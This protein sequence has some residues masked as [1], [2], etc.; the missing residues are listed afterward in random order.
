M[1]ISNLQIDILEI[2]YKEKKYLTLKEI[3]RNLTKHRVTSRTIQRELVTLIKN[4]RVIK[5]G[6]T[7]NAT[8]AIDEI[9]KY[10]RKFKFIFVGKDN[11]VAGL[12]FKLTDSYRFYYT[13]TF[14]LSFSE[15][16]PTIPLSVEYYDFQSIPPIFEENIPE[17][18]NREIIEIGAHTSDEFDLLTLLDDN[19]GDLI[20]TKTEE[21]FK[22]NDIKKHP[23]Y[24]SSLDEILG[25][26]SR[27]NILEDFDIKIDDKLLFPEGHDL[28]KL[29]MKMTH[30]ISGFQYKRL[31]NIDFEKKEIISDAKSA[32]IY[33]LKPYS[34]PKANPLNENYFPHIS[35]NEHLFMSFAKNELGFRVPYSAI[36]KR[37][38]DEEY[39]YIVKR[40][41]RLGINR[42]AKTTFAP[43]LGLISSTKYD[44]T[45]EKLFTRIA[46]ELLAPKERM[47]LL[48][49]YAYSVIIQHEDMH[50]K[51]L[52]LILES[53]KTLFAPLYD[54]SCTGI[55]DT[56]KK[57][58]SM[59]TINGKQK[60]I[61]PNDFKVL[62]KILNID[63]KEFKKEVSLIAT[64]YKNTLPEYIEEIKNLGSIPFYKSK[65]KKKI[66][67]DAEWVREKNPI[68]FSDVLFSFYKKRVEELKSLNWI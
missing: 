26:N 58:D 21:I 7:A 41:D 66:G 40:F 33:I 42:Y 18:I 31:V 37:K 39:H 44:T 1:S 28:S 67:N 49:H 17:G 51:N 22:N 47:E 55:Y 2:L 6:K 65:L 35:I 5:E 13:N 57:L 30:G 15:P 36:V 62:C 45:S 46:K 52:S 27:I 53:K 43:Y 4:H 32:N 48:K 9:V 8:Y 64:V 19:I 56:T 50:T 34:N 59:L 10:Y 24:L 60:N 23:S 25:K 12:F 16:I 14:L 20:F 3:S 63:F 11:E 38:D 68:E 61:R 54:I 29:E